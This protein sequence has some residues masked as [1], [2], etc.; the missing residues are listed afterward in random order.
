MK[1]DGIVGTAKS[2]TWVCNL[3]LWDGKTYTET[4]V[5]NAP[6]PANV[7]FK[8]LEPTIKSSWKLPLSDKSS[9]KEIKKS[10]IIK[11]TNYDR[12]TIVTKNNI[13]R[14][15][16][17]TH[18]YALAGQWSTT[19]DGKS[20]FDIQS[21]VFDFSSDYYE[22][23]DL[24]SLRLRYSKVPYYSVSDFK[25]TIEDKKQE[26]M[27]DVIVALNSTYDALTDASEWKET[28]KLIKSLLDSVRHP[29]SA[30]RDLRSRILNRQG[31]FNGRSV[32]AIYKEVSDLWM[33][34]RYGIMPIVYSVHDAL[35]LL[36]KQKAIY[37]T[38]RGKRIIELSKFNP[39]VPREACFFENLNGTITIRGTGKAMGSVEGALRAFDQISINPF[40][41]AWELIPYSFVVDW[42]VNVG[43]FID[44]HLGSLV[45]FASQREH[46]YAIAS[47][48]ERDVYFR[49]FRDDRVALSFPDW[50]SPTLG[51]AVAGRSVI[52]GTQRDGLYL[53]QKNI[54]NTYERRKFTSSDIDLRWS[55]F[56]DWKRFIDGFVLGLNQT[57]SSL[58]RL[59]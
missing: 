3:S 47:S 10:G 2:E 54:V 30:F 28:L 4:R 46:C 22:Q 52:R 55:P 5:A 1:Y 32:K 42:F 23:G 38:E 48:Y 45:S 51:I 7:Q 26:V 39:S 21:H 14:L 29:L 27:S 33:E 6:I 43:D 8:A 56:L 19:K 37:R 40:K 53:L 57:R 20:F 59:R 25:S 12:G 11:M 50:G 36:D 35:E 44:A 13:V 34:Y 16:R 31:N 9:F 49:D 17:Q 18:C 24:G 58:R 41:T 15:P